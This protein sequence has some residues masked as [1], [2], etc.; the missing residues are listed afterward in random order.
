MAA[1]SAARSTFAF[2]DF[3]KWAWWQLPRQLR[4]Y[5]AV[6]PLAA[7]AF[8]GFTVSRASWSPADLA[9]FALLVSCG[10]VSVAATPRMNYAGLTRDFITVWLLPVAILLPAMYVTVAPIPLLVLTQWRIHRGTVHRR[11]FS[12]AA[13]GLS[14]GAAS[15]MFH[16]LP[17]SLGG[18]Q[19]GTG[20]H[21]LAWVIGVV[22]AELVGGR[23]HYAL[24]VTA[25]KISEP[26]IRMSGLLINRE[27]LQADFA[28]TDLGVLITVVVGVN[29][30]LA[31]VAVPT[32][33][34]I[35]RFMM[36]E[37]LLAQSRIDTKTG[38]LN[39]STWEAEATTEV[40]RAIRTG[41]PLSVALI[42]IDHFKAVNDTHGHLVGDTVL[43]AVTDAIQEHLR[44]YDR[45]GRFGGEEFVVLLPQ[46]RQADAINIAERLRTRIAAMSIPVN[47]SA[48]DGTHVRLTVSVGVAALDDHTKELNDLMAAADAALYH[49]K[50]TGRNRTCAVQIGSPAD[51]RDQATAAV[52]QSGLL[53]SGDQMIEDRGQPPEFV[54]VGGG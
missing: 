27:G 8:L 6:V 18:S 30:V 26:S 11:V 13:M 33:L 47:E 51:L 54:E 38:L 45:A 17:P 10:L 35:R 15:L 24:I 46:A 12:A 5:V 28:E 21:A 34:L 49:A 39:S 48:P 25:V 22:V 43:R 4:C 40:S 53:V 16:A 19:I 3:R 37:Q 14:Y 44:N 32:V 9:K 31:I 7:L 23:G 20:G 2:V 42:D 1:S 41:S 52:P 36:H 29:V 50:Q